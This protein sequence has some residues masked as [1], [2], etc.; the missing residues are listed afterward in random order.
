MKSRAYHDDAKHEC[1][2]EL[3]QDGWD[4]GEEAGP[5]GFLCCGAP[6]HVNAEHMASNGLE[7]VD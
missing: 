7:D 5:L 6:T 2:L 1:E 4:L 3:L